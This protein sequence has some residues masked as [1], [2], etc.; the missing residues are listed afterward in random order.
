MNQREPESLLIIK[1]ADLGDVITATPALRALHETYPRAAIDVLTSPTGAELLRPVTFVDRILVMDKHLLDSP[2][3]V[4][5]PTA[6]TFMLRHLRQL[7]RRSYDVAL[8][9]HHLSTR[10]G[11][12]K[13]HALAR[14][15]RAQCVVGLDNGRGH[16]LDVGMTDRGFGALHEVEYA[17]GLAARVGA[18]THDP[19][20]W[21]TIPEEAYE[22]ARLLL[23]A[24]PA[25]LVAIH[26]GSGSYSHARR[27]PAERFAALADAITLS[28][29]AQIVLVGQQGDGVAA[30]RSQMR[31]KAIDLSGHTSIMT[32]AAVLSSC[33]LFIGN[34]SGV[35]HLATAVGIPVVAIFG[36]TSPDAW[37]PWRPQA[38][39][40][41]PAVVV[42]G[43][44]PHGDH[45]L[46]TGHSVGNRLGCPDRHCLTS[47]TPAQILDVI[48]G[49]GVL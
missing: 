6:L 34:D 1:L 26:P 37:G 24:H 17:L 35:M 4:A 45:C 3:N 38:P 20:L 31:T 14:V 49:L 47:I 29:D 30:V 8:L 19:S 5:Q 43:K 25:P 40:T 13:W 27:W 2:L 39:T 32:L 36:P 42:S 9:M 18:T 23:P 22:Q 28:F 16:F 41:A 10:I 33:A 44:C 11:A 12:L 46:Y 21:V 7:R 48:S 15:I